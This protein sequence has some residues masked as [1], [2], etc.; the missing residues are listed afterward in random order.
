MTTATDLDTIGHELTLA[1]GRR[2][3]RRRRSARRVRI[4]ALVVGATSAFSAAA[5][6]SGIADGLGLGTASWWRTWR[7]PGPEKDQ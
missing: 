6:A 5:F 4:A 1:L 3:D 2:I 7:Q